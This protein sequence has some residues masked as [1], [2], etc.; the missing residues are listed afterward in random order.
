MSS[1]ELLKI[2]S[3]SAK[4]ILNVVTETC[5]FF[6]KKKQKGIAMIIY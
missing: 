2:Q 6:K 3:I 5:I 4:F 1:I